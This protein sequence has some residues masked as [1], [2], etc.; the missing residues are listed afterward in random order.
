MDVV[1]ASLRRRDRGAVA[2]QEA[3]EVVGILWAHARPGDALQHITARPQDDRV[4]LLLYLLTRRTAD[5]PSDPVA[6]AH[7]LIARGHRASPLL[8]RRYHPPAPETC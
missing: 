7:T 4:D 6:S 3:S 2:S 5:G 1:H 8:S